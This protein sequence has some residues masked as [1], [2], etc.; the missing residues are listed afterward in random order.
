MS[1]ETPQVFSH[2]W[3]MSHGG[4]VSG[5]ELSGAWRALLRSW[6]H[7]VMRGEIPVGAEPIW[8]LQWTYIERR[9]DLQD[10]H[11][12]LDCDCETCCAAIRGDGEK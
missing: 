12:K 8:E 6:D 7:L 2:S 3:A 4:V 5:D 11:C 10:S 9:D 1:N